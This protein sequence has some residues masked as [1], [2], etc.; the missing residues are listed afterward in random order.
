MRERSKIKYDLLHL[1]AHEFVGKV[2]IDPTDQPFG[3]VAHPD[4]H[5]VRADILL[6]DGGKRVAKV[7]LRNFVVVHDSFENAVKDIGAVRESDGRGEVGHR[8]RVFPFSF[9]FFHFALFLI[10][11]FEADRH[12]GHIVSAETNT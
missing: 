8:G 11:I 9:S 12:K 7:I 6:A 10:Y 3:A 5:D 4:V 2:G 1:F